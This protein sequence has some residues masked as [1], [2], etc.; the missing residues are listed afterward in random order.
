MRWVAM[1][2]AGATNLLHP[3]VTTL[4]AEE[5]MKSTKP[6][7]SDV[8]RATQSLPGEGQS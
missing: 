6:F 4:L 3:S 5:T 8:R 7:L 1:G 2:V